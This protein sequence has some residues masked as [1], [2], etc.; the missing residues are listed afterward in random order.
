MRIE[1]AAAILIF[2]LSPLPAFSKPSQADLDKA[3]ALLYTLDPEFYP[4][5]GAKL[6]S[7]KDMAVWHEFYARSGFGRGAVSIDK[8]HFENARAAARLEPANGHILTTYAL[9]LA[10][11]KKTAVA[12]QLI[13]R[14]L[15][16]MPN[17][18][19]AHAAQALIAVDRGDLDFANSEMELAVQLNNKDPEV[20][21]IAYQ[22]YRK[23][24]NPKMALATLDRWVKV[25]PKDIF[26]LRNRADFYRVD[27]KYAKSIADCKAALAI[28]PHY[29]D[30]RVVLIH[31]LIEMK[32]YAGVIRESN[33]LL[34]KDKMSVPFAHTWERRGD[35][36]SALKDY[37]K[38]IGDYSN[39][40]K[41][42]NSD[43]G[44]TKYDA[45]TVHLDSYQQQIYLR[46]WLARCNMYGKIGDVAAALKYIDSLLAVRPTE[47]GA[48]FLRARINSENGKYD[49]ALKD[50]DRLIASDPDVAE[51][52]RLKAQ[53]YRKM[54][55]E[56]EAL[57]TEKT[58]KNLERF[59]AR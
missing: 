43:H 45:S 52:Y 35:A 27:E 37:R 19:R 47:A 50:I 55:K 24:I 15:K 23:T 33:K 48:V 8:F 13:D 10:Y 1:I 18:A 21:S 44:D 30:A 31:A 7:G 53:I 39:V 32:D 34:G 46:S 54:K 16:S 26:A 42:F 57:K 11:K 17:D 9:I 38:A 49:A 20:N 12:Q 28:N 5:V 58:L 22:F 29:D 40:I 4:F 51:W 6:K 14:V 3:N 25:R 59:G 2:L 41:I 36:Y 56:A